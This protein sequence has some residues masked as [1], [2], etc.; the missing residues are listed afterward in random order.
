MSCKTN[1]KDET[2]M[3]LCQNF[4]QHLNNVDKILFKPIFNN[5]A[6]SCSILRL[7]SICGKVLK[8]EILDIHP[9]TDMLKKTLSNILVV[10]FHKIW[11]EQFRFPS[12]K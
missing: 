6:I 3:I 4:L 1:N 12:N 5:I 2:S 10:E 8:L 11:P 7:E 9:R